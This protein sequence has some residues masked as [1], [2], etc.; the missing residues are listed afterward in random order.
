MSW[1]QVLPPSPAGEC[2]NQVRVKMRREIKTNYPRLTISI[3]FNVAQ[4]WGLDDSNRL[5]VFWGEGEDIGRMRL[6][7]S[8]KGYQPRQ[9]RHCSRSA[10]RFETAAFPQWFNKAY[11]IKGESTD[12]E[13]IGDAIECDL[14][15]EFI[16][17]QKFEDITEAQDR[18]DRTGVYAVQ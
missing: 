3:G 6:E 7:I 2:A 11:K 15:N 10:F 14:P 1:I 16:R 17:E 13:I 18:A 9:R 8:N 4:E 12:H 5:E